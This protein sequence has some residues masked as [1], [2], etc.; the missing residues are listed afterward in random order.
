MGA[1]YTWVFTVSHHPVDANWTSIKQCASAIKTCPWSAQVE[2]P[3]VHCKGWDRCV[4]LEI[5]GL[6]YWGPD[7]RDTT[8]YAKEMHL[9]ITDFVHQYRNSLFCG[10]MYSNLSDKHTA[11]H[12]TSISFSSLSTQATLIKPIKHA[13]SVG[14][15]PEQFRVVPN[16][17]GARKIIHSSTQHFAQRYVSFHAETDAI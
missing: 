6:V 7:H 8:T 13:F 10:N 2:N 15:Q 9:Q 3:P 1:H 14:K 17:T 11:P 12:L 4:I 16:L 5:Q